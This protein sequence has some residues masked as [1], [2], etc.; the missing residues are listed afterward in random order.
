M[1]VAPVTMK[2][3]GWV[4]S[5]F[6]QK[7]VTPRQSGLARQVP[8]QIHLLDDA[9]PQGCLDGL[10]SF[11]HLWV[12]FQFHLNPPLRNKAKVHPPRL[13]GQTLGVYATRSPHRPNPIGLSVVELV[14]IN[15]SEKTLLIKGHDFVDQTPV[16]DIK[17]YIPAY[18]RVDEGHNG[19]LQDLQVP[20][21]RPVLWTKHALEQAA[22]MGLSEEQKNMVGDCLSHDVRPNSDKDKLDKVFRWRFMNFDIHFRFDQDHFE[23]VNMTLEA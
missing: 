7:F 11:S 5:P 12:L 16:F 4:S 21:L 17:P 15:H 20:Q 8:G 1:S 2:P 10:D 3:I 14:S 6:L 19:W 13:S 22:Q 23:V 9:A 18:D